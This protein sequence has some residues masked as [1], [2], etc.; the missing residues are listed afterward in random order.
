M[1]EVEAAGEETVGEGLWGYLLAT[2][3]GAG[4]L[5]RADAVS[6]CAQLVASSW[7]NTL[8]ARACTPLQ[9]QLWQRGAQSRLHHPL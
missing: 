9:P 3:I 6:S 1:L 4:C 8:V 2:Q 7:E 5:V